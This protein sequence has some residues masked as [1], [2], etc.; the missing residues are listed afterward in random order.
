MPRPAV[1]V[2]T[3]DDF[4]NKHKSSWI[5][6]TDKTLKANEQIKFDGD[7]LYIGDSF[8]RRERISELFTMID[9]RIKISADDMPFDLVETITRY[10]LGRSVK[11][12]ITIL[13]N[14]IV[15]FMHK[16]IPYT[17]KD[18]CAEIQCITESYLIAID[19]RVGD[20]FVRIY[21]IDKVR[22]A[23]PQQGDVVCSGLA[24]QVTIKGLIEI[25]PFSFRMWCSNGA[26]HK[27][28]ER[29]KNWSFQFNGG[30]ED[31]EGWFGH[32]KEKYAATASSMLKRISSLTTKTVRTNEISKFLRVI[33]GQQHSLPRR[34]LDSII[35][36]DNSINAYDLW[37]LTTR[38][39]TTL[40]KKN[41]K[42]AF[43]YFKLGGAI[44]D[45]LGGPHDGDVECVACGHKIGEING[46]YRPTI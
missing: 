22:E 44:G 25:Y 8:V 6:G 26:I 5:N 13:D 29:E 2:I 37:N 16:K 23:E 17:L 9:K 41:Y 1:N 38:A 11:P 33:L 12:E 10:L 36:R 32:V 31:S 35:N 42:Q 34:E 30:G 39:Y 3:I 24:V 15:S 28:D 46:H 4:L 20:D 18:L 19:S 7:L 14:E 21:S 43:K 40:A 45:Y 27:I